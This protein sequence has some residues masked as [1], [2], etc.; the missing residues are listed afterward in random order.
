MPYRQWQCQNSKPTVSGSARIENRLLQQHLLPLPL[1]ASDSH[2][3]SIKKIEVII[4]I[5]DKYKM[6][7]K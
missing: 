7:C 6:L 3:L 5:Y 4:R 1:S 2:L